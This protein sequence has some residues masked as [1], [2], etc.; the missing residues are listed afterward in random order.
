[1]HLCAEKSPSVIFTYLNG[2]SCGF[3][4]DSVAMLSFCGL[5]PFL[6]SFILWV[7]LE[8]TGS[9]SAAVS[10]TIQVQG[11]L[12]S[13]NFR[14]LSTLDSN[15]EHGVFSVLVLVCWYTIQQRRYLIPLA[16]LNLVKR[17][18]NICS[19]AMHYAKRRYHCG[20]IFFF[21]KPLLS[22]YNR[23]VKSCTYF[24]YTTRK[25]WQ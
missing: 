25:V 15:G 12:G 14:L 9:W 22:R 5:Y 17:F 19:F 1:M 21:R 8:C 2:H 20:A 13:N 10:Q 4:W 3:L 23:W 16:W 6:N 11:L 24:T 7:Y 18:R